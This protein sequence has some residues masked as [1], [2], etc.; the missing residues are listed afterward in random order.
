MTKRVQYQLKRRRFNKGWLIKSRMA[1]DLI[2]VMIVVAIALTLPIA[3]HAQIPSLPGTATEQPTEQNSTTPDVSDPAPAL[4][5][6]LPEELMLSS[7]RLDEATI[8]LDGR[9]LFRVSAPIV[10]G[11]RPAEVRAQEIQERLYGLIRQLNEPP[12]ITVSVD[13][14]SNLPVIY[15][16]SQPLLTVTNADAQLSSYAGPTLLASYWRDVLSEAFEQYFQ[17]RSSSFLQQQA[18]RALGIFAGALILQLAARPLSKRLN[19]RQTRLVK[20]QTQ[21]G[22]SRHPN[23]SVA[24]PVTISLASVYEQF[25]ARLDNRQKRKINEMERGLLWLFQIVLWAGSLLWILYLFPYSRWLTVLLLSALRIPA[26]IFLLGGLAYVAV[27]LSSLIIDKISLALRKGTTWGPEKS[28]RLTLRFSTF[29]QVAK[30]VAGAIILAITVLFSLAIAGIQI[31]PLLAGA[32]IVGIG[33]SLAA[34]SLIK[35]IINGFLILLEDHFGIG[36]VVSVNGLT[37]AVEHV[38]LRITQLRDTEG[39]LITIPNSQISTVQNLSMDWAQVDLS[40]TVAHQSDIGKVLKLLE[41]I[42]TNLAQEPNWQRLILEPPDVLGVETLDSKG[43]T[44]RLWLKTQPLQQWVVARELRARIK[45]AFDREGI[46][47]GIPQE[48]ITVHR[49]GR[50]ESQ[51]P[52]LEI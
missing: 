34:Q 7:Q 8:Y 27:R 11:Q 1:G 3:V 4:N 42:A 15:V 48:Q 45:Q 41:A 26:Q 51:V 29:S 25:K 18:K 13:G 43:I 28:Q 52:E 16:N 21:L 31:A 40:V 10:A 37:G 49:E 33:I 46:A 19:R 22:N 17:E 36:D 2:A 50:Q 14:P 47:L 24:A 5:R 39:R 30:G 35:D 44:L 32:G 20:A 23:P 12:A 6:L 38:N 9:E